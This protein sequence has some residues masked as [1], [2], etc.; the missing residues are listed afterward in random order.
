MVLLGDEAQVTDRNKIRHDPRHLGV[1]S[2]ASKTIFEHMV[3]SAQT[4]HLS[5]VKISTISKR[6]EASFHL[7]LITLEY[8]Q[9]RPKQ[10]LSLW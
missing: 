3:C 5:C 10:F 4:V 8:H 1:R 7:S 6:N 2:G 9:V